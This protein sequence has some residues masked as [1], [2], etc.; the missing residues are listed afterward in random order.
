MSH[1]ETGDLKRPSLPKRFY[2]RVDVA[3]AE[4]LYAPV[5]DGKH[6]RTPGRALLGT[7]QRSLAEAIAEEWDAQTEHIDPT[8]MPLTRIA[9]SAIDGVAVRMAETRADIAAYAATDLL[10]YRA[11]SPGELV[12]R[13]AKVWDPL[14][15]WA[16]DT[17]GARLVMGEGVIPVDQPPEAIEAVGT[18]LESYDALALAALHMA[19]TLTGSAILALA[20]ARRRLETPDAWVAAHIDEDW[21]MAQWGEDA[22]AAARRA[23]KLRDF[24]AAALILRTTAD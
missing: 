13:Q 19:T 12:E 24:E 2:R 5:L 8:T 17:I 7:E 15:D 6:V 11:E 20:L 10:C 4:G 18:A 3:E 14:L 21:Q 1:S 16:A 22:E 23:A 9:N